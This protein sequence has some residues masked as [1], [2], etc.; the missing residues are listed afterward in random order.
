MFS[1]C[2]SFI[3]IGDLGRE[4]VV[5]F[6][7]VAAEAKHP[8]TTSQG[9]NEFLASLLRFSPLSST[10]I[11]ASGH[12]SRLKFISMRGD[13]IFITNSC[14]ISRHVLSFVFNFSRGRTISRKL[15]C[16]YVKVVSRTN[17]PPFFF[18]DGLP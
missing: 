18:S 16:K 14:N 12:V 8:S 1:R 10:N 11:R 2:E 15:F 5:N 4:R 17:I 3:I 7:K 9:N 6:Y 13:D